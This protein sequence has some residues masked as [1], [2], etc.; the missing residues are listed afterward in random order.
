MNDRYDDFESLLLEPTP[1]ASVDPGKFLMPIDKINPAVIFAIGGTDGIVAAIE[2][3][4]RSFELDISTAKGRAEI[5]SVTRKIASCRTFL[6]D[7]GKIFVAEIKEKAK[8]IDA[9]RKRM[10]EALEALQEEIR[11][12]LTEFEARDQKRIEGHE[13]MLAKVCELVQFDRPPSTEVIAD[14][15]SA[16]ESIRNR[17]WDEFA[18]RA[19][20]VIRNAMSSLHERFE[21]ATKAEEEARE[22]ARLRAEAVE[23]A[24]RDR[25]ERVAKETEIRVRREAEAK[26][27]RERDVEREKAMREQ[28][29]IERQRQLAE[30]MRRRAEQKGREAE[31]RAKRAEEDRLVAELKAKSDAE[32]AA[33]QAADAAVE[34][35]R[36]RVES[37]QRKREQEEAWRKADEAHQARIN[38][39]A[40]DAIQ[41]IL[42]AYENP[43]EIILEAI[44]EGKIPH[45]TIAY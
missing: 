37:E 30:D 27:E 31:A 11:R 45:V 1:A 5:K 41:A 3:K 2:A 17:N 8:V 6:D 36:Q 10:R 15:I 19:E 9:E 43:A 22:L 7:A 32:L 26:A 16:V 20:K 23:R 13:V 29:E 33:R 4:A 44:C 42:I 24:Q 39:E 38:T 40:L 28:R 14:R 35:F 12:P 21:A 34:A 25:E 18:D